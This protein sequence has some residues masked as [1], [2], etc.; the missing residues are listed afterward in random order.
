M[1]IRL[2]DF[3]KMNLAQVKITGRFE[4]IGGAYE[5]LFSWAGPKGIINPPATKT[6]TV[7]HNSHEELK[8]NN[9]EQSACISVE[10]PVKE[11]MGVEN[12]LFPGGKYV[13]GSF[14]ISND[15]FAA[16]WDAVC[17]WMDDNGHKMAKNYPFELYHNN[18]EDHPE[19]KH[20]V[21][22]CVPIEG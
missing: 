17:K 9:V 10:N 8:D 12:L 14:E 1:K 20:V 19:K 4:E 13:V 15:E 18:H 3:P 5:K 21:D 2:E 7:Y 16:S 6:M 11:E 22:I